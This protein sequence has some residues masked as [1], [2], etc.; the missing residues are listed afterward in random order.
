MRA[1]WSLRSI[2]WI[3]VA[4]VLLTSAFAFGSVP[5]SFTYQGRLTSSSGVPLNEVVALTF[6]IYSDSLGSSS[7]WKE[8]F[9][10]V[11]V[12]DGLFTV[13]LGKSDPLTNA[14]FNGSTRWLG[15]QVDMDPELRPLRPLLSM[16]NTFQALHA[17]TAQHAKTIA[18]NSVTSSKIANSSITFSDIAQNGATSGQVMKWNGSAWVASTDATAANTSGWIDNGTSVDLIG[19][20]DTVSLSTN[21]RL[22]KLNINGDIGLSGQS[23]I[24]FGSANARLEHLAGNDMKWVGTDLSLMS[25]ES[26][27]FTEY[28]VATWA[29]FDNVNRRVGIGTV[30]PDDRLHIENSEAGTCWLKIQGSH[31]TNW[32]QT[33]LRIQTPAN[34]WHLRQDLYT[35]ANF[36]AGALSL[37]SSAMSEE[38]MTWLE[39]GNVGIGTNN[40]TRKLH[41]DGSIQVDDTLY[42]GAIKPSLMAASKLP[43]E[44]G[45][46]YGQYILIGSPITITTSMQAVLSVEIDVPAPGRVLAIGMCHFELDHT[47]NDLDVVRASVSANTTET[48]SSSTFGFNM[49][50]GSGTFQVTANPIHV[51]DVATAGPRTFY[52]LAKKHGPADTRSQEGSLALIYLPTYYGT[53]KSVSSPSNLLPDLEATND[54]SAE[55][56]MTGTAALLTEQINALKSEV[57]ALKAQMAAAKK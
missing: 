26:V 23:A 55:P 9:A 24:Y 48:Y 3:S 51:F 52:L 8:T 18:D 43:D 54:S 38:A 57:E 33:G 37:Y 13:E 6:N 16:P 30:N 10:M 19:L 17:D 42:G 7:I 22:G 45:V 41:V 40:P 1:P 28:G 11:Q 25:T 53:D 5:I 50:V 2:T 39:D 35:H 36:P 27:Y 12:T 47:W 15:I 32:G 44:A 4:L 21:S 31:P 56:K 46:A 29:E 49:D 14:I 34:T 20:S